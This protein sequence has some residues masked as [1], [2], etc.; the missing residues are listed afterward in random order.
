M[1]SD[2]N[3]AFHREPVSPPDSILCKFSFVESVR[4]CNRYFSRFL[5]RILERIIQER[6]ANVF[7]DTL[8]AN[9]KNNAADL[10][11]SQENNGYLFLSVNRLNSLHRYLQMIQIHIVNVTAVYALYKHQ[12]LS[13]LLISSSD[14]VLISLNKFIN[15]AD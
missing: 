4:I 14:Q 3:G 1:S 12:L 13:H 5:S 8:P 6:A 10:F 15:A 2:L 11:Y 7:F 9:N